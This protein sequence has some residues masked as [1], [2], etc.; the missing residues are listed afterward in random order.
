MA[1]MPPPKTRELV[2]IDDG[3]LRVAIVG[4]PNVGELGTGR[5]HQGKGAR[6]VEHRRYRSL[7]RDA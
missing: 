3:V 4:R 7:A 5:G 1:V 2:Q 6:L